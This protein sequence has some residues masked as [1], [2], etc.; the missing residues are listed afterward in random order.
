MP[1]FSCTAWASTSC[2]WSSARR[3][4]PSSSGRSGRSDGSRG[5]SCA[6]FFLRRDFGIAVICGEPE[7]TGVNVVGIDFDTPA[8][9]E[10]RKGPEANTVVRTMNGF[11]A[12]YQIALGARLN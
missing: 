3:N 4:P 12:W 7:E 6:R 10:A 2:R 11:H 9:F 1:L 8:E 5:G